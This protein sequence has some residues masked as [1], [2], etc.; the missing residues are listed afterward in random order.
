MEVKCSFDCFYHLSEIGSEVSAESTD[1]KEELEVKRE[2]T[3][4]EIGHMNDV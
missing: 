4:Y 2:R 3:M 1:G